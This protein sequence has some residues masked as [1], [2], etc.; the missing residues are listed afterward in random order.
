LKILAPGHVPDGTIKPPAHVCA[1]TGAPII[2]VTVQTL[3]AGVLP[4]VYAP[5][6]YIGGVNGHR[7]DVD[8]DNPPS[9][10]SRCLEDPWLARG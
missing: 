10:V 5:G 7:D 6:V 9:N 2:E 8:A 3:K 1:H 4:I